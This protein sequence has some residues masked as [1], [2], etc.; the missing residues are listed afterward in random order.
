ML[1]IKNSCQFVQFV[2]FVIKSRDLKMEESMRCDEPNIERLLAAF[3]RR[4]SD[5]V[6]NFEILIEDQHVERLLGRPAG[7][8]LGAAK[9]ASEDEYVTPPMDPHDYV[10]LCQII[11]Q[12]AIGLEGLW[13]PLKRRGPDGRLRIIAEGD[14]R[15]WADL[16]QVVPHSWELDIE[17]KKRYIQQY[18][19]ATK[20]TNI[21]VTHHDRRGRHDAL[22]VHRGLREVHGQ[23]PRGPGFRGEGHLRC[24]WTT[25]W[26]S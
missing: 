2:E 3:E 11:G 1:D 15:T 17:P 9:G 20:G 24:A 14:I 10:E 13:A 8:T 25:T 4:E 22:P 18:I 23:D 7:H 12:D 6:P 26:T 21:G 19:D 16:D 5:R